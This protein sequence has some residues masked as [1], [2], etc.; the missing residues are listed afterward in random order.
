MPSKWQV[1]GQPDGR[2]VWVPASD[3]PPTPPPAAAGPPAPAP[4]NPPPPPDDRPIEETLAPGGA[5]GCRVHSMA[6]L[7]LEALD[8]LIEGDG[9]AGL[10]EDAGKG[11]LFCTGS[12]RSV[13]VS[14]RAVRRARALVGD[15]V[16]EET[17]KRRKQPFGDDV[18]LEGEPRKTDGPLRGGMHKDSLSPMF[19][20][21][22]G[23][24]VSLSEDSIQKAR[25]VLEDNVENAAGARQPMFHTGT[26]R[27]VPV[28]KSSMDK[29]RAVLEAQTFAN[30]AS[31]A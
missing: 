26:G 28:S 31:I 17:N 29:A 18:G 7:L 3:A 14:E 6:D 25:A 13:A 23:K 16:E 19:Q 15:E 9:L 8:K 22:S 20:T 2:L 12:R 5:D 10:P 24:A 21:G 4:P 30:E 1:W 27:L 11:G